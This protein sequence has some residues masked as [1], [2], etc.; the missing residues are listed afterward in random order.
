MATN[1]ENMN[2][3][4]NENT[5]QTTTG[6]GPPKTA[7]QLA[8]EAEKAE[9]LKKFEEKQKAKAK[10]EEEK[11]AKEQATGGASAK[12]KTV[13]RDITEYTSPTATGEKKDIHCELPKAYSP[14]YVEAAWYNWWEKQGFFRP[15]YYDEH[16]PANASTPRKS[17]TMVI[18]PPN[19]TGYLHLG[20]AIM[21][22]LEDTISRWHRM[23]GETVLWVPGCDHAGIAT[24][25]VVEKKIMREKKLSR[26]DLGREKFL[27]EV[28]KWKNEK[29]D[30]IYEQI[31][32]LGSSCDWSRKVFT[33]DKDMSYAVEEAFIRMH[34]KKLIYRSTR[35]VNWSCTLKSAISDIEVEKTELKG[36]TLIR[37]PGYEQ[38]VE[39]GVLTF[40]AYPV[41]NSKE[42]IIVATTRLETMLGDTAVVVHPD[43]ERYKHLHGKFV[44]H[45]FLPRRI[46][47][48]SDTMV[49]PAFGSGA[50]KITPA[51]DQNDF[52]CGRRLN[53]P[54]ITCINGDGLMSSECGPYAGKPRFD[55][56][57]Q[58]L[59]DL[60]ERG[61]YRDSKEN[62]M[63]LPICS[64][65]KD[66]IEPL[67]KPQWYVNCQSMAQRSIDAV[68][69]K[70][71]KILPTLFEPVWYRW[72]EDIRDWCISRQLWW[73]H[74][75]PSYFI[76]S[77]DI[78]AGNDT[79]DKY[80]VS[81]HSR[82]EAL[83]KAAQRFNISK[84]KI[85]LEQDEDVLDT[86]FSSGLFPFSSFGW[87][88]ETDDLKR[89]FPTTL[90]ETGH[91][92]I[93]FWVARMVMMSLELTDRLPFTEIYLHAIIRDAHGRKMSKST[94]NVIDPLDVITGITLEKLHEQL[95][96]ANLDPK[97]YERAKQG[98]QG[99]YPKGI[100]ECGTDALRF[101]L[102]SYANQGRDIN[103]DVLRVEGYR[104]FC[105]KLWNAIRFAMSKNLD[106]NAPNCFQPPAEFKLT[107][108]EKPCDLWIISR[109]SHA[110]QQCE[111]GFKNYLFP[112]ITTAIYNFWLYELC[113]V[114]IE[115]VK[116]DL[117]AKE[118]DLQRQ[119]TIKLMLYTCLNNGL[120]LLAP[121]MPFVSEELFQ[122]LP[123]PNN[124]RGAPPS[125]CVT[126][127]PQSSEFQQYR[128]ENIETNVTAIYESINK[129][130]SYRSANKIVS[131]E[132]DNLYIHASPTSATLF[133]E[134]TDLIQPLANIDTIQL[135]KDKP[136]GDQNEY[137]NIATTSD[138]TF[139][140]KSK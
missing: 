133:T 54:F 20:H 112:Q 33:M 101:A 94:G 31:K 128:N 25:V 9:K 77:D 85:R 58:L 110:I 71:L 93:F 61:L 127:Y 43:D 117:Y 139:Y 5:Q 81:A 40:F 99:D 41:E 73:G 17:F 14:K 109:L 79:D 22:T 18:P 26:H 28:W 53:L 50:V 29:G 135:L 108:H 45:P 115:Y 64:R 107:G 32:A 123:K 67:L 65:S 70:E 62:E 52:D 75:I 78:P 106:I 23:C 111:H 24:Q 134:Y 3:G 121:I 66:I 131:K 34:E 46:P 76:S 89:F 51:H 92:I 80:W 69:S 95:K 122:R 60:K 6:E 39:F 10:A 87:P 83:D 27:E 8:K 44:Q 137:I 35:L 16:P 104:R 100:P 98:Q 84:E 125:L 97:E 36:K 132:K 48:L 57:R 11:K 129:I 116:K 138:Y 72:L 102:C 13:V 21:C 4:D 91:D 130:R 82:E 118:P 136:T 88:M 19:V 55:V 68:R 37:V 42:E 119:E 47:I 114:Y 124:G 7:K 59:N 38:P 74:R 86:W 120:R 63:V 113:D 15:E 105:N 126:P 1:S 30:H 49:D 140:F 103:L 2:P 12:E 90:L 96:T 56:R